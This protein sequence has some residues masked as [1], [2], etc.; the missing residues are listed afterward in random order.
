MSHPPECPREGDEVFGE[1]LAGVAGAGFDDN[2]FIVVH[3]L[4]KESSGKK[5]F[6]RQKTIHL[7]IMMQLPSVSPPSL[8]MMTGVTHACLEC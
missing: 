2:K 8:A 6:I 5:L 4:D 7:V 1:K 3:P